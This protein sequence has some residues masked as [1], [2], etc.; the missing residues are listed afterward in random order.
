MGLPIL[1]CPTFGVGILSCPIYGVAHS[2]VFDFWG[3]YFGSSDLWHCP[4]SA[5]RLLGSID[6]WVVRFMV[7]HSVGL[8]ESIDFFGRPIFGLS[9]L[10]GCP[11]CRTFGVD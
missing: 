9:D 6:F 11:F 7:A 3:R 8:L 5:V 10:W 2:E 4:F 1:S